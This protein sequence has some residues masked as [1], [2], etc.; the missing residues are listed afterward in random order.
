[1]V[2]PEDG[3]TLIWFTLL[4]G[5]DMLSDYEESSQTRR[6]PTDCPFTNVGSVFESG[7]PGFSIRF[8]SAE[9]FDRKRLLGLH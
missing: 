1:M 4:P 6:A 9:E 8:S 2:V 7:F 5:I 3:H